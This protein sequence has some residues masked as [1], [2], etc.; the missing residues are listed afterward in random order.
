LEA[1][2]NNIEASKYIKEMTNELKFMIFSTFG[3]KKRI[4][5]TNYV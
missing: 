4:I 1:I 2:K 3:N 5:E